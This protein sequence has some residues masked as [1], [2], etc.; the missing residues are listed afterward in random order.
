MTATYAFDEQP[1]SGHPLLPGA[2]PAAIR[3]GLLPSDRSRFEEAYES[4]LLDSRHSLDLTELFRT[5]ER[6][7]RLAVMQSQP[8]DYRRA[9]RRAAEL[10]TGAPSA[11]DEPLEITRAK[12]GM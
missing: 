10:L 4:A 12:A 5:L 8:E 2:S 3:D 6:W 9:V 1:A 7:R 11:E